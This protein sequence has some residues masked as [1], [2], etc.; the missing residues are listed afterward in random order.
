M[1]PT[2]ESL[3]Q[4]ADL[5]EKAN[6][7]EKERL[8]ADQTA[9]EM[10]KKQQFANSEATSALSEAGY[11]GDNNPTSEREQ[12][13]TF[14]KTTP[15]VDPF[16]LIFGLLLLLSFVGLFALA[17]I[18]ANVSDLTTLT[19]FAKTVETTA[20]SAL[21][22]AKDALKGANEA[23]AGVVEMK[24]EMA[25]VK[26]DLAKTTALAQK[27][28]KK[29]TAAEALAKSTQVTT[30][31]VAAWKARIIALERAKS[32]PVVASS[33]SANASATASASVVPA[34]AT[35]VVQTKKGP[36]PVS[37]LN[38]VTGKSFSASVSTDK[39]EQDWLAAQVEQCT[40]DQK[41]V[42]TKVLEGP[43]GQGMPDAQ[44]QAILATA[45][46]VDTRATK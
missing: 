18:K 46:C 38:Q 17:L 35:P 31:E 4:A 3:R 44:K 41:A 1:T 7:A 12:E 9:Q 11:G 32:A 13:H 39:E 33:A 5:V 10:K 45:K 36:H 34:A 22:Q 37:Y 42:V 27:A 23:K 26:A 15:V 2:P 24:A 30:H 16:K 20:N 28:H 29:A 8:A 14:S 19:S 40:A 43:R 21:V 6:L 25:E